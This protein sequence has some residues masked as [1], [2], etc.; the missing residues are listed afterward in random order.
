[1]TGNPR[2][3]RAAGAGDGGSFPQR[4]GFS[5]GNAGKSAKGEE[6]L[7]TYESKFTMDSAICNILFSG[8]YQKWRNKGGGEQIAEGGAEN[9]KWETEND[10]K[11]K[12][13]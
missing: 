7:R 12:E 13:I 8:I 2:E 9:G 6:K 5:G 4:G 1:M 3:T 11:V 10:G